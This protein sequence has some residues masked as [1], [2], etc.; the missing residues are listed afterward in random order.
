MVQLPLQL[1]FPL[2]ASSLA[3]GEHSQVG[4]LINKS[5]PAIAQ[6]QVQ[7][8]NNPAMLNKELIQTGDP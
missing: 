3:A 2:L 5:F 4:Q 7:P 8:I 1:Q 6:W